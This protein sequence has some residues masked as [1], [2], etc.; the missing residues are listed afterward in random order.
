MKI[1]SGPDKM[2]AIKNANKHLLDVIRLS[3]YDNN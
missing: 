1:I 2:K 3:S